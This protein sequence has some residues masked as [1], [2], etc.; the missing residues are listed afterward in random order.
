M[1]TYPR[2]AAVASPSPFAAIEFLFG[3][4]LEQKFIAP[5]ATS[6]GSHRLAPTLAW[7]SMRPED[8][9]SLFHLEF[10]T[11]AEPA[12]ADERLWDRVR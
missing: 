12:L 10:H 4:A 8:H 11:I 9:T 7:A 3:N 5:D 1:M 2:L 6:S